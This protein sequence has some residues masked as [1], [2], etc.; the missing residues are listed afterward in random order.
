MRIFKIKRAFLNLFVQRTKSVILNVTW[1]S[2]CT[3][4]CTNIAVSQPKEYWLYSIGN[5]H[6][7]DF[8]PFSD[9]RCI[10]TAEGDSIKNGW[11]IN[12]GSPLYVTWSNPERTCVDPGSFGKFIP[13]LSSYPWDI[14][15][16][17]P[18]V[19][20]KGYQEKTAAINFINYTLSYR[21]K[22]SVSF[23][24]Y[25]TWPMNTSDT[26]S[27]FDYAQAWMKPY[28]HENDSVVISREFCAY[29]VDSVRNKF[30][31]AK[32]GYIPV[33]EVFYL[34]NQSAQKGMIPGF[35]NA[36]EL[37]R[38]H[39]HLN[40]AGRYIASLTVYC[41]ALKK[42][43]LTVKDFNGFAPSSSW[44]S[45]KIISPEQKAVFRKIISQVTT[46]LH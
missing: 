22:D 6:T 45:D 15:T 9:F 33:G 18:F 32:I 14:I 23:F 7:A 38:D 4:C 19:G 16:I 13:A 12:C 35:K 44:P 40:N 10:V 43:P 39:W 1:L 42:N 21:N 5:S 37:Y 30:P 29:L 34:F 24:L 2:L 46:S 20:T 3:I 31:A 27:N 36:G 25:C 28:A 11:H 41:I 17:Q 8:R 26:L